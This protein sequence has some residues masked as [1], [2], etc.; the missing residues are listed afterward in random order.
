M[1][2]GRRQRQRQLRKLRVEEADEVEEQ[3]EPGRLKV[4]GGALNRVH[5]TSYEEKFHVWAHEDW[6]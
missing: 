6:N 2:E 3:Q 1:Q 5:G 4:W